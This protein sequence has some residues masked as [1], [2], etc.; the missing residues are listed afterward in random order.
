MEVI[1]LL[2]TLDDDLF[3]DD[4]LALTVVEEA[5]AAAS[6]AGV[7]VVVDPPM[8]SFRICRITAVALYACYLPL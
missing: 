7:I 8:A 4:V 2:V 6:L 1:W 5:V 3:V